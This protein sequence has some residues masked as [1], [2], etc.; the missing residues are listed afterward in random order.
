[1]T[2]AIDGVDRSRVKGRLHHQLARHGPPKATRAIPILA[3]ALNR[4]S[5][6][7]LSLLPINRGRKARACREVH[8]RRGRCVLLAICAI[9]FAFKER[10][11]C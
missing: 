2:V 1:M 10:V 11:T 3:A 7:L 5:P 9:G 6:S 4:I 8:V